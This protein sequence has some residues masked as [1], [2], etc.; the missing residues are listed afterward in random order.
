MD[1]DEEFADSREALSDIDTPD[2][3]DGR[4][5]STPVFK[6]PLGSPEE[7][8]KAKKFQKGVSIKKSS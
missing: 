5:T 2:I 8:S 4:P 6:R 1:S 7:V 3:G